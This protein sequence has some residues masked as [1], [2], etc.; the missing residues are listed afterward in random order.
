MPSGECPNCGA[1]CHPIDKSI[2]NRFEL[3]S[4]D[5]AYAR[6]YIDGEKRENSEL[7]DA[8]A[9]RINKALRFL[10]TMSR[11]T[12]PKQEFCDADL[13]HNNTYGD[14]EEMIENMSDERLWGEYRTFM[15][16]V[17]EAQQI[18]KGVK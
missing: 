8:Y 3:R 16:M 15:T 5:D 2:P 6:F 17:S 7:D 1:L 4:D 18:M 12:T 14:V 13:H 9:D 11:F 10:E